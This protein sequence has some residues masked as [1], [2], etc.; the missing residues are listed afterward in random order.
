MTIISKAKLC[1]K[2]QMVSEGY[3]N[4]MHHLHNFTSSDCDG[5]GNTAKSNSMHLLISVMYSE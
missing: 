3:T 1:L 5:T 4:V 2:R